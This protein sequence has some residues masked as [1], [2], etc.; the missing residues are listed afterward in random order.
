MTKRRD[1]IAQIEALGC[2]FVRE[3]GDHTIYQTRKG[4]PLAVPRHRDVNKLTAKRILKDAQGD[5]KN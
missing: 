2:T 4:K 5:E 1:L 3:G